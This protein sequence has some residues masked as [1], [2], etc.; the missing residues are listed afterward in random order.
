MFRR[1]ARGLLIAAGLVALLA[2]AGGQTQPAPPPDPPKYPEFATVTK[3]AKVSEGLFNLYQKDDTLLAEIQPFQLDKPFLLPIAIAK[4]AG[5]GGTTLN[6]EEQWVIAFRKVGDKVFVVRKNVRHTAKAGTPEAK[7]L[8]TTYT[9]SV[10]AALPIKTINPIKGSVL[11][12]FSQLFFTDIANL[13]AG[14]I[15][16]DRT[17]W[18]KVKAFKKNVELQVAATVVGAAT[19]RIAPSGGNAVIDRRGATVIIHYSIVELPDPG[20]QTRKADD[21]VGHFTT[22]LKDFSKEGPDSGGRQH[23]E[24]GGQAGAAEEEDR[25]LDREQRAGGVPLRRAGGHPGVEQGVRE[26]G[27]PRRD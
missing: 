24:G 16:R 3:G 5:V 13:G 18:D 20:Y 12:D 14:Y 1:S 9:D 25:L 21:R 27:L 22:V 23:L 2:T 10:L 8:D 4:G 15:D 6:F 17:T 19:G 11:V 7:A 26:G